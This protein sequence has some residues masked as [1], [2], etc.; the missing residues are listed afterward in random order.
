MKIVKDIATSVSVILMA[1]SLISCEKE[2]DFK[3]HD[4]EP[5]TVIEG[6]VSEN[7]A[8][9]RI[10]LTTPMDEPMDR[11]AITDASVV[12]TDITSATS[13]QLL[14]DAD[15]NFVGNQSGMP[16]HD[17]RLTVSHSGREYSAS[18]TML[19][20]VE[21]HGVEFQ[22]IKMPYDY[23]AV[24]QISFTDNPAVNGDCYWVR[25]YRNGKA[26]MWSAIDDILAVDGTIN[27][28]IMTSRK[29]L[30]EEDDDMALRDGD[31]VSVK[32]SPISKQMHDYLEAISFGSSNGPRMFDGD[33]CL[34]YFLAAP[35]AEASIVF[36]PDELTE[37]K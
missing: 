2:L 18:S 7:G 14:P 37:Y 8:K 6:S 3:Y 23:V 36:H 27:E 9:V 30:D 1:V 20:P 34:G 19:P 11:V 25:L 16:G 31:V 24:L 10:S 12:L 17:Y 29:D 22:W 33:F 28:V 35:V 26:Y 5:L 21:I 4:I 13:C 15:G 32:V